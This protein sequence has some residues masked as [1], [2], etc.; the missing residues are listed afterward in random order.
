MTKYPTAFG[1]DLHV[2]D[3]RGV[4][5]EAEQND[6]KVIIIETTDKNWI[7][8]IRNEIKNVG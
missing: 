5:I 8:K 2:D 6:F 4:K 7:D 3:S 1:F